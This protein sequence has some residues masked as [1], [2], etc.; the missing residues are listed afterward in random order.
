[1]FVDQTSLLL[2][3]GFAAFALS[4]TLFVTWLASRTEWFILTW[5]T[6]AGV[7]VA[8][9]AGF[10]INA[11]IHHYGLLW[12]SNLLL[13][14]SFIIF[15]AAACLFTEQRLPR[16]RVMIVAAASALTISVPFVLGFDALG[17]MMGNLTNAALLLATAWQFW[18]GRAEAMV[19][20]AGIAALYTLTALSFIP[21][22]VMIYLKDPLVLDVPP[23]GWAEDLNSIV[24][25]IGL[26]GI[27][28]LSLALNQARVARQHREEAN[29]DE[30]TGLLNRRAVFERFR[31]LPVSSNTSVLVFDLDH[32]KAINDRQGHAAGDEALRRFAQVVRHHKPSE[33]CAARI[34]GE[35]FLLVLPNMNGPQ[36]LAVAEHIRSGFAHEI[37]QGTHGGFRA[38]VSVGLSSGSEDAENFDRLLR[39]ADDALYVAK[40]NG[41]NRV[42][43]WT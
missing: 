37:L 15:F 14:G 4:A 38:T 13:S 32:F 27:G 2:A 21:C 1:M 40:N 18:R 28:A 19:W 7:L 30:L 33:A 22:A 26:T 5:A 20:V 25:L 17:A 31:N 9:F 8:A 23:S 36:A 10:S 24:G 29:T 11:V 39:R 3:L 42:A 35:E 41:R 34:G 43:A 6:G 16:A 12:V